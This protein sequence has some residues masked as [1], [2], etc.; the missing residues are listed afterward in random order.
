[1]ETPVYPRITI[2]QNNSVIVN[3]DHAMI[4]NNVWVDDNYIDGTVY[5]YAEANTYYYNKHN[6]DG[7]VVATVTQT[8]P[9]TTG[10]KTS[11]IIKNVHTDEDSD[12]YI[13]ELRLKNNTAEE[14][15]VLDVANRVVSSSS[16][17][18]IFGD[19]FDWQWLPLYNGKN[20]IT[21]IG[22][23]TVTFEYRAVRKI[24][25]Y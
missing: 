17:K 10:T 13:N 3:V 12:V 24:G 9:V 1:M 4:V 14:T 18:R 23:C 11:V 22:N 6:T 16:T 19:D 15:I 8:N 2:Q 21:V 25:E 5:Y 7:S 20:E